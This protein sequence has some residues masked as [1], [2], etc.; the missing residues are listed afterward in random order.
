[1]LTKQSFLFFGLLALASCV[2]CGGGQIKA[3]GT[4]KFTDGTPLTHGIVVFATPQHQYTG[5]IE[6]D[7]SFRLGGL[8][9]KG[10][11]PVGSYKVSIQNAMMGDELII[12]VK[13]TSDSS[14]GISFEIT[15][16]SAK[17]P[18]TITLDKK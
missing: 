10:G 11:L 15:N 3:H 16:E 9:E 2:G 14:S 8:V 4:V 17:N 1:M 6:Q 18:L 5:K 7:G 12:P 13:Y